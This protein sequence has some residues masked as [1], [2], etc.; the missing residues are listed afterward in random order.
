MGISPLSISKV[1]IRLTLLLLNLI[2]LTTMPLPDIPIHPLPT[3]SRLGHDKDFASTFTDPNFDALS[4]AKG[5][6]DAFNGA[7]SITEPS[8]ED[9]KKL[10]LPDVFWRDLL[11]LTWDFR[12][13]QGHDKVLALVNER[14]GDT[15][16][17]QIRNAKVREKSV[18][19]QA[20]TPD[21]LWIQFLFDFEVGEVGK[22]SGVV[23]IVPVTETQWAAH[24]VFT[25]LE[26]LLKHPERIGALR[27]QTASHGDWEGKRL[28]EIEFGPG[29]EPPQVVIVG[30]GHSG[31]QAA[32]R[33]KYLG[34]RV[35]VVEKNAR[36]GDS[37]RQRYDTLTLHDPVCVWLHVV[38]LD[39]FTQLTCRYGS[40]C[41]SSVRYFIYPP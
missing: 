32:A 15:K 12:T 6:F 29:V 19:L 17:V 31:L 2:I 33:L 38:S 16:Q 35:L 36:V 39:K 30:A 40:L 18:S 4:A 13:L 10:L 34:V 7:L 22:A 5:W 8:L 26:G 1:Y 3:L 9:L 11:A 24:A 23:R 41:L 20:V 21:L 28:E 27:D 37:W 25:N 14:V